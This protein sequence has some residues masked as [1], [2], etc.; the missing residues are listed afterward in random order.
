MSKKEE[1]QKKIDHLKR[2]IISLEK[3][4]NEEDAQAR[5]AVQKDINGH[6]S[7]IDKIKASRKFK[8]VERKAEAE[9]SQQNR[10]IILLEKE[11]EPL[12]EARKEREH[13]EKMRK[14]EEERAK[15]AL[16]KEKE[17]AR[18]QE[19]RK[20]QTHGTYDPS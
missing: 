14:I 5:E 1:K 18:V 20:Y 6:Q 2:Q 7:A 10:E 19:A 8:E 9:I 11:L 4:A 12:I 3:K 16:E 13:K 15:L 17:A